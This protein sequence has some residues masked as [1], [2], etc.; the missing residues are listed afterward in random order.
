MNAT[1]TVAEEV[2]ES[3]SVAFGLEMAQRAIRRHGADEHQSIHPDSISDRVT[4]MLMTLSYVKTH[5]PEKLPKT[6]A[7]AREVLKE[8]EAIAKAAWDAFAAR[9]LAA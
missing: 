8:A 3:W 4:R 7:E 9:K 5:T 1:I 2:R 6:L